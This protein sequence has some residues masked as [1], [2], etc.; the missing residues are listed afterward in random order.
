MY[1]QNQNQQQSCDV[2]IISKSF[3][4]FSKSE[5]LGIILTKRNVVFD[6]TGRRLNTGNY[7]LQKVLLSYI[8]SKIPESV[9]ILYNFQNPEYCG[10]YNI[11]FQLFLYGCKLLSHTWMYVGYLEINVQWVVKKNKK[12]GKIFCYI[13]KLAT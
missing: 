9:T 3:E 7:A 10:I 4:T 13:Q 5:Y 12:E 11:I 1:T 6:E 2:I 8:I